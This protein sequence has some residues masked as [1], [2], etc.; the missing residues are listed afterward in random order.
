LCSKYAVSQNKHQQKSNNTFF[1]DLA[2]QG[3]LSLS[4]MFLNKE[5]LLLHYSLLIGKP[6]IKSK[7]TAV[8]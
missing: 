2:S 7:L 5:N 4:K 6:L 1:D 8:E 3:Y